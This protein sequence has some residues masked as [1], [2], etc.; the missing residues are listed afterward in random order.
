MAGQSGMFFDGMR[1]ATA[2]AQTYDAV[3]REKL[4]RL[5]LELTGLS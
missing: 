3:A 4:R 2:N 1:E 5:S